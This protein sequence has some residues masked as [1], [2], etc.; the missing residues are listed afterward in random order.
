MSKK[1]ILERYLNTVYF[2]NG[3]YGLQAAA[4]RYFNTDVGHLTLGQGALLASLIRD[5]VGDDPFRHPAAAKARRDLVVDRMRSLGHLSDDQVAQLKSEALPQP[6]PESPA[7]ASDYFSEHVK[8][9]LLAD[10]RLGATLQ[11]RT[12]ALFKGGLSIHTTLDPNDQRVAEQAVADN[13]PDSGGQFNAALVS[14]DPTTGAVRALVGGPDFAQSK[15]NLATDGPGRQPGSSFKAFTLMAALEQGFSPR[16][17]IL[18]TAPCAIPNPGGTPDPWTPSNVEGEEGGVLSLTDATVH[19]INCAYARLIKLIG[20][21]KVV[22]VAH[23]MGVTNPLSPHLSLTLGSEGVTPL[24]MASAYGTLAADGVHHAPYFVDSVEDRNGKVLFKNTPKGD[25]AVSSDNARIET[26]VLQQ[27]VQRGTGTAA[28]VPG[29][30]AAGK[31]GTTDDYTNAWFVGFTPTLTTAVWMGSP[32][33]DVPMRNVGGIRVF[34]GTYPAQI[35]HAYMTAALAGQP[36][37]GF[38][39]P[40]SYPDGSQYRSITGERSRQEFSSGY[41]SD[42]APP[43]REPDQ[44]PSPAPQRQQSDVTVPTLPA[45]TIPPELTAPI[46]IPRIRPT[47]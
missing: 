10:P 15:F 41:R 2:G 8:Q 31:T 13:L 39:A 44:S 24:Q 29:W 38:P 23:R 30:D 4:E 11:E 1:Q 28:A 26:Q 14:L 12:Y 25:R 45:F 17:T 3:A 16:D 9:L 47:R 6:P 37:A 43:A 18:G 35:W 27:V 36:V 32:D 34:G 7:Q 40:D 5:P 42:A 19:S 22:D 21:D 33:G 46:T 20:P